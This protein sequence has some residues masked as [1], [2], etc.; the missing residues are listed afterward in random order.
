MFPSSIYR[1]HTEERFN[2]FLRNAF[3]SAIQCAAK[4]CSS[5]SKETGLEMNADKTKYTV[6]SKDQN[7]GRSHNIEK[8]KGVP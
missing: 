4:I 7:A 5:S 8:G 3:N 1:F 2:I 6:T